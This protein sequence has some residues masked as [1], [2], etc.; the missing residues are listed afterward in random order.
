MDEILKCK[1]YIKIVTIFFRTFHATIRV[2]SSIRK[3]ALCS[4]R[5]CFQAHIRAKYFI[6]ISGK[7]RYSPY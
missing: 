3:F 1:R 7:P 6:F 4:E 5:N 2:N